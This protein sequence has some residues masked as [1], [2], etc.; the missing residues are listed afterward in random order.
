MIS[1]LPEH[2]R[3]LLIT[4]NHDNFGLV[5]IGM[6]DLHAV[7]QG[8][9]DRRRFVG[10][11]EK[12]LVMLQRKFDHYFHGRQSLPHCPTFSKMPGFSETRAPGDVNDRIQSGL[13][14]ERLGEKRV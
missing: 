9:I 2:F 13:N 5:I 4:Q 12:A 14:Q 11:F 3:L 8:R 7:F 1:D 10:V 6:G